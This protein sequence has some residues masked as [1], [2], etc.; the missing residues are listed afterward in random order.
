MHISLTSDWF[1]L[2]VASGA[3]DIEYKIR[4]CDSVSSKDGVYTCNHEIQSES[5]TFGLSVQ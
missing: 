5:G 2:V 4:T 3:N 1:A